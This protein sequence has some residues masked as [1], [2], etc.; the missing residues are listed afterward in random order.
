MNIAS[1]I[2]TVV[3]LLCCGCGPA[4]EAEFPE[5]CRDADLATLVAAHTAELVVACASYESLEECP[6]GYQEP[7]NEAFERKYSEWRDCR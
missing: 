7:I 6:E 1:H 5:G 4:T 3:T 2:F